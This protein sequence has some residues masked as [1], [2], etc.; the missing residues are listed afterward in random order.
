MAP[1]LAQDEKLLFLFDPSN[2]PESTLFVK[3]FG[4]TASR[5]SIV[6]EGM[7]I[8]TFT[9]HITDASDSPEKEDPDKG[10]GL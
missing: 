4:W 7:K 1:D 6:P 10:S 2:I 5:T 3:Y 8:Y 9:E